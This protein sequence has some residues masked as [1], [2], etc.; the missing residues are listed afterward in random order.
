MD[1]ETIA[2]VWFSHQ[3][4]YQIFTPMSQ[5]PYAVYFGLEAGWLGYRQPASCFS[6]IVSIQLIEKQTQ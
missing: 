1:T 6:S 4:L 3:F 2:Q 5:F